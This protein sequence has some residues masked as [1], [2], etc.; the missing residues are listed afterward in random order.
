MYSFQPK[1]C[2]WNKL[3]YNAKLKCT[4]SKQHLHCLLRFV[5][6][7]SLAVIMLAFVYKFW[8]L[9]FVLCFIVFLS[10]CSTIYCVQFKNNLFKKCRSQIAQSVS[11]AVNPHNLLTGNVTDKHDCATDSSKGCSTKVTWSH[12][13]VFLKIKQLVY[14]I[15]A[16]KRTLWGQNQLHF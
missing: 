3:G 7:L 10:F 15:S 14:I 11:H 5:P 4:T 16:P 8:F 6:H 1:D 13:N 2:T 9:S 12:F